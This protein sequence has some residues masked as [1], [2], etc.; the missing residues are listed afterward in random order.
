MEMKTMEITVK[1]TT[2]SNRLLPVSGGVPLPLGGAKKASRFVLRDDKG[3]MIPLQVKPLAFWKDG[4]I[5]WILLDFISSIPAGSERQFILS[6]HNNRGLVSDVAD[7][8]MSVDTSLSPGSDRI[9]IRRRSDV[10][11]T[12]NNVFSFALKMIDGKGSQYS[13]CVVK[14]KIES[15]GPVK[16]VA[17]LEG[18]FRDK[19]GMRAIDFRM[20]VTMY[21][22]IPFIRIEP[23]V[24]FNHEKGVFFHIRELTLDISQDTGECMSVE[25]SGI[26]DGP[27]TGT[28]KIRLFQKDDRSF[29]VECAQSRKEGSR[30]N[31][32]VTAASGE[33]RIAVCLKD[34]WQRWPKSI[35]IEKNFLRIGLFPGFK[36]GDFKHMV[37]AYKYQYLFKGASYLLKE[38]QTR[39][40]DIWIDIE[41]NDKKLFESAYIPLVPSAD[42]K[43]A[44]ATGAWGY[45]LPASNKT[46]GYDLLAKNMLNAYKKAIENQRDYG[47]M[48]WGDWFGERVCNWGNHEYD[49][50]AHFFGQFART[51][52]PEYFHAGEL[53]ARHMSEVDIIHFVNKNL[54][55]SFYEEPFRPFDVRPGCVH[56]HTIGHVGGFFPRRKLKRL[57]EKLLKQKNPYL[58]SDP[59]NL[60]HLWLDGLTRGYYL[61]GDTWFLETVELVADYLAD[62]VKKRAYSFMGHAHSGRTTG[63]PLAALA[64]AYDATGR[65]KY[66]NAM[67]DLAEMAL[68]EQDPNCGGWLYEMPDGHCYC[69]KKKHTGMAGFLTA[70]LVIGLS[71]YYNASKDERVRESIV[72][73]MDFLIEDTWR[74]QSATWRYTSCP[75]SAH[76]LT[77]GVV[78]LALG[79][80]IRMGG[81][82]E[83]TRILKKAWKKTSDYLNKISRQCTGASDRY[84]PFLPR[85]FGIYMVGTEE[86]APL[87]AG[88]SS[89]LTFER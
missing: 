58:C 52:D 24:L 10:L 25:I 42:P 86:I 55:E 88:A 9:D 22:G 36:A 29:Q 1:N 13:G 49:T 75:A 17:L 60:G 54:V 43:E 19:N 57:L 32:W 45:M 70:I 20:R 37:P 76:L 78:A 74:E 72:R 46:R 6:W 50:P 16:T 14:T 79:Y 65:K 33:N 34:F 48:N 71:R 12:V 39:R 80:S 31:G 47:E 67:S 73:A 41:A 64:A 40:W 53:A 44:I 15:S 28:H 2:I 68:S 77:Y 23:M 26:P 4:S 18:S 62:I 66:L 85:S 30:A 56:E 35:E 8:H 27:F 59:W 63:W 69:K 82:R 61:T 7:V 3:R 11:F 21:V 89:N 84:G 87:L 51:G 81:N 5:R 38:G 83:Q